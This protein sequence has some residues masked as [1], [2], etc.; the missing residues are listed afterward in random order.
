MECPKCGG[1]TT[2][3]DCRMSPDNTFRRRR[4][5]L[6]CDGRFSTKEVLAEDYENLV[7][8]EKAM[9]NMIRIARKLEK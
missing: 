5:C 1:Q 7:E 8:L 9:G 6:E 4:K 3:I 2:V